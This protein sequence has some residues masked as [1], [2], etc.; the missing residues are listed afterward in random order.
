MAKL[1]SIL[2]LTIISLI[3]SSC[4]R[5]QQ[6]MK[7]TDME[8]KY[9]AAV[10]YFEKKDYYHALQLLEELNTVYRGTT[11]AEMTYYYYTYCTYYIDDFTLAAYH[12][13]NYVQSYPNS[14]YA[15]EMQYMYAYCY[16][17]DSPVSSLDQT[18]T[19]DAI[20]KFQIFIN[21]YPSS[22]RVA[23]A[24]KMIDEL[25]GKLERKA[26]D[27]A[28]LYYRTEQYKAAV[29]TYANA[30]RDYPSSIYRERALYLSFR[31][32]FLYADNS[33]EGKKAERYRAAREEYLKLVDNFPKSRYLRDAENLYETL[34]KR[35][36]ET[37]S[38]LTP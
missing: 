9:N 11:K 8:A 31:S 6:L 7:S 27:N 13:N 2:A 29:V 25:R 5:F 19:V 3:F 35:L 24:N 20:D 21:R 18:S 15:E 23:E 12:F 26:F 30:M 36:G 33:V 14:K 38:N 16:Y 32:A 22:P 28:E 1:K 17:L 4:S 10:K 37:G 34:L